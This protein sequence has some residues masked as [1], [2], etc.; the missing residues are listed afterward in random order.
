MMK[1]GDKRNR[2]TLI[3]MKKDRINQ[4]YIK[5]CTLKMTLLTQPKEI[6]AKI[7]MYLSFREVVALSKTSKEIDKKCD[8]TFWKKYAKT[9]TRITL[10]GSYETW[11]Q[12]MKDPDVLYYYTHNGKS[13]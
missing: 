10:K 6:I 9:R 8:E 12:L 7:S 13:S 11:L 1:C 5:L 3:L 4:I 2:D